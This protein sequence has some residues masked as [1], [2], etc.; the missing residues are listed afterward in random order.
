V[1]VY[2]YDIYR[3][4]DNITFNK[5]D[6]VLAPTLT[7]TDTA[8]VTDQLY[9][10]YVIALDTSF[11]PSLPSNAVFWILRTGAPWRDL[12]PAYGIGRTPIDGL[13]VGVMP[14]YGRGSLRFWPMKP[15]VGG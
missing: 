6:R 8:V 11:N 2:A 5:I 12:P 14:E 13:A 9:Y 7:Y 3:S 1:E 15:A 10:Y 4:I